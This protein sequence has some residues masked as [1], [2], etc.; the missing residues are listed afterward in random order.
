[1]A[2]FLGPQVPFSGVRFFDE[3]RCS[4]RFPCVLGFESRLGLNNSKMGP[5][6]HGDCKL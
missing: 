2:L 3:E 4:S 6:S 1:M 5:T